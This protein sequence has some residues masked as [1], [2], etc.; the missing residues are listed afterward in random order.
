[1]FYYVFLI[2]IYA[3][4]LLPLWVF[5]RISDGMF[6]LVYHVARYRRKLVRK[7]LSDSFP[8]KSVEE[9]RSI[10][11]KYYAWF[12]DYIVETIKLFS[13][14]EKEMR[15]RITFEGLDQMDA[16]VRNGRCVSVYLGHYC[17]W[18]WVSSLGL[19]IQSNGTPTQ[20]YHPLENPTTNRLLLYARGRFKAK[21]LDMWKAFPILLNWKKQG[22][23]SITGYIAD[24]A[25]LYANMHYWPNF[26]H[27]DTPAFTGAERISRIL[28]TSVYYF[29]II[30]PRRGYYTVKTVKICDKTS[31]FPKFG[32]TE[33][34][35]RLLEN[36]IKAH[37]EFWLWSHNRW[38]RTREMF[39][40]HYP[41]EEE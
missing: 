20:L 8:E 7:N 3:L 9:I 24:Q 2:L 11:K 33:Q 27:H 18:E 15:R 13:V 22:K 10:E 41:D 6:H 40:E 31:D 38:K 14:S 35:F 1:M 37:P 17:N 4:S 39:N 12:C 29:D 16:D 26:L 36:S 21:S 28:D 5:Y 32:I 19:F 30:R 34:Y 23:L 25:P